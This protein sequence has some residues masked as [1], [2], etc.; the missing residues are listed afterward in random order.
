[1]ENQETNINNEQNNNAAEEQNLQNEATATEQE[2][3][4]E[5][6]ENVEL[7]PLEQAQQDLAEFK[8]KYLRLVAEFDNYRKRTAKEKMEVSQTAGKEIIISLLEVLDDSDRAMTQ[9]EKSTDV[10][11]VKEGISLVFNKLF[12]TLESRGLTPI[13]SK[14]QDFD[15]ELHEALTEI[16]APTPELAGKVVDEIQKGY[17]LNDKI[18]RHAKVVVGK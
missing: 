4:N 1:M 18:I 6:T 10:V 12:K 11:A 2:V 5:Q 17:Y 15:V 13:E 9:I 3:T 8:D 16:P 14:G 7:S